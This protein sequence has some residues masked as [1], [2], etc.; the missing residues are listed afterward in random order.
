MFSQKLRLLRRQSS[1]LTQAK[2]AEILGVSQQAVGLWERGKNMPSH[3]LIR[4]IALYFNVST[5]YLLDNTDIPSEIISSPAPPAASAPP[6]TPQDRELLRKYH[7]LDQRGRQA[8]L[9]TIERE[10][11]YT[12]PKAEDTGT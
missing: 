11:S 9:D 6:I 3:D 7:E 4:Q 12:A 1:N 10:H 8:V 5:D 2:L